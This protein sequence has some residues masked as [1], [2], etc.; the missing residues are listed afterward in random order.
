MEDT[1]LKVDKKLDKHLSPSKKALKDSRIQAIVMMVVGV[2]FTFF[3]VKFY[4][5]LIFSIP[6]L[7]TFLVLHTAAD[8]TILKSGNH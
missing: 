6:F 3:G 7:A 4:M 8:S 2:V 5:Y 1:V